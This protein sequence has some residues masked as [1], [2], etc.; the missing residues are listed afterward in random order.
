MAVAAAMLDVRR[1][2]RRRR[3]PTAAGVARIAAL[4]AVTAELTTLVEGSW[5]PRPLTAY[6]EGVPSAASPAG[7]RRFWHHEAHTFDDGSDLQLSWQVDVDPDSILALDLEHPELGIKVLECGPKRLVLELPSAD[8]ERV[9]RW[10]HVTASDTRHGCGHLQDKDLYH[11]IVGFEKA[12]VLSAQGDG[13]SRLEL[14]TEELDGPSQVFPHLSFTYA[15]I[16]AIAKNPDADAAEAA[17]AQVATQRRLDIYERSKWTPDTTANHNSMFNLDIPLQTSR[18]AWNW[19]YDAKTESN[20]Q[21]KYIFPGGVGWMRLYKPFL[22]AHYG[23][24]VTFTSHI[25]GLMKSPQVNVTARL[26]GWADFNADVAT[27]V[28]FK[29]DRSASVLDNFLEVIPIPGLDTVA[30]QETFLRPV[31]FY[32]GGTPITVKPGFSCQMKAY[33]IGLLKGSLR[34]GL[35]AKVILDGTTTFETKRGMQTNIS[36]EMHNVQVTPPTWMVFTNRFEMGMMLAPTLWLRGGFGP[37]KDMEV[38]FA[39]RPFFNISIM[40]TQA[41]NSSS[42]KIRELAIYPYRAVGLPPGKNYVIKVSANGQDRMTSN[43]L[44][45]GIVEYADDVEEFSFGLVEEQGLVGAAFTVAILEDGKEPAA[46]IGSA[47]CQSVVNGMCSPSPVV[48]RVRVDG[49]DA[50]VHLSVVWMEN[51]LSVLESKVQSMSVRFPSVT[52]SNQQVGKRLE[53]PDVLATAVVRLTRNGRAFSV[54]LAKRME[55]AMFLKSRVIIELGPSFLDGWQPSQTFGSFL[56]GKN[57]LNMSVDPTTPLLELL[58]EDEVVGS[59]RMPPPQ[60]DMAL[61]KIGS[62][63]MMDSGD[64]AVSPVPTMVPMYL[65]GVM[66]GTAQLEVDVMSVGMGAYWINPFQAQDFLQGHSYTFSWTT[67][68]ALE[69]TFY[70]FTLTAQLVGKDGSLVPTNW[71]KPVSVACTSRNLKM[72]V[73]RYHGDLTPC[74]FEVNITVPE[75]LV[76]KRAVITALWLDADLMPHEMISEPATFV[77]AVPDGRRRLGAP[78]FAI[79]QKKTVN[80]KGFGS[81]VQS[82]LQ[83]MRSH[84]NAQALKYSLGAGMNFVQHMKNGMSTTSGAGMP[85]GLGSSGPEWTSQ[86]VSLFDLHEHAQNVSKLLPKT[87]CAG[88]ACQGMMPG[89]RQ[90]KVQPMVI[91]RIVFRLSRYFKWRDHVGPKMRHIVAYA[92]ALLP[93]AIQIS[94]KEIVAAEDAA[95][96]TPGPAVDTAP[97]QAPTPA[98]SPPSTTT[99][100]PEPAPVPSTQPAMPSTTKAAASTPEPPAA[101]STTLSTT[102]PAVASTTEAAASTSAAPSTTMSTQPTVASTTVAVAA[103]SP[104]PP[105]APSPAPSTQ[106]AVASTSKAAATTPK[107]PPAPAPASSTQPAVASASRPAGASAATEGS[108]PFEEPTPQRRLGGAASSP[109]V[110]GWVAV[111]EHDEPLLE[112]DGPDSLDGEDV[113]FNTFTVTILKPMDYELTEDVLRTIFQ[114]NGF[115]GLADGREAELGPVFVEGAALREPRPPAAGAEAR[116]AVLPSRGPLQPQMAVEL[117]ATSVARAPALSAAT[118]A[119]AASAAAMAMA[120]AV[121]ALSRGRRLDGYSAMG[122]EATDAYMRAKT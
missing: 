76:G 110:P 39:V 63:D 78:G 84:C 106:P 17:E 30:R 121:A 28:N 103:T 85:G 3:G 48:A 115:R 67:H 99:L 81:K 59:G 12:E 47:V 102:Q 61:Q 33:H 4:A 50:E 82:K 11:R 24:N 14:A 6:R 40:Q 109:E 101:S 88:G 95:T 60:W 75:K 32:F 94:E 53:D 77:A 91:K 64:G 42:D 54:P 107:P 69:D 120:A 70:N 5:W 23:L 98:P 119:A 66:V 80:H 62:A 37:M 16:P 20:P 89:C 15:F 71:V 114:R 45:T 73:H 21:F 117:Q 111:G 79:E 10:R 34:A 29:T 38:G 13:R 8:L 108:T 41:Q 97:T 74:A 7:A 19:D 72:E 96:S 46:A 51:A 105:A 87:L 25:D 83:N 100:A 52:I 49:Q 27:A 1:R 57:A 2:R 90:T 22:K 104:H 113:E 118:C 31:K 65:D 58:I 122:V 56:G 44:S 68:G 86:P 92:L 35:A 116:T 36:A 26:K 112:I 93:S 43:Q 55:S 9:R 18:L